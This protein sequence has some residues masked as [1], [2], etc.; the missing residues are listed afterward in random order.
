MTDKQTELIARRVARQL[1]V[2]D[3]VTRLGEQVPPTDLQS[4]LLAVY[5]RRAQNETP[6][7]LLVRFAMPVASR[8]CGCAVTTD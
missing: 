1:G 8:P 2:E 7:R 5:R 6:G 4:L 3:L